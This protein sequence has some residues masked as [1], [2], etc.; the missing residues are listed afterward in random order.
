MIVAFAHMDTK[1]ATMIK[2]V[3]KVVEFMLQN[4]NTSIPKFTEAKKSLFHVTECYK[5]KE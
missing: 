5:K 4:P 2:R 1:N 3:M